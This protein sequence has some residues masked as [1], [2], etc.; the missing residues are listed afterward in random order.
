MVLSVHVEITL[1]VV[2]S[3]KVPE[4]LDDHVV[5]FAVWDLVRSLRTTGEI[6]T[7][8]LMPT[9]TAK[10]VDDVKE[11]VGTMENIL[12]QYCYCVSVILALEI[13]LGRSSAVV[14]N[15]GSASL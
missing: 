7:L 8:L 13:R 12:S 5:S 11:S 14:L 6:D 15:E 10:S 3:K 2:A 4:M 1:A 9:E